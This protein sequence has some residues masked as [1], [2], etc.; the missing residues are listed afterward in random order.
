MILAFILCCRSMFLPLSPL[1]YTLLL[2]EAKVIVL[3][4]VYF[5]GLYS[6]HF[7]GHYTM[8][9]IFLIYFCIS[10]KEKSKGTKTFFSKTQKDPIL[11][12]GVIKKGWIIKWKYAVLYL[13][14]LYICLVDPRPGTNQNISLKNC[15]TL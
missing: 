11:M 14:Y 9:N 2:Y 1:Y 10:N 12:I 5:C 7:I 13:R 6:R 8:E 15:L 3:D 4:K